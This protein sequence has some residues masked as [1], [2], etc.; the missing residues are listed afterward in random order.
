MK[1]FGQHG[2][3]Y[4]KHSDI[5]VMVW[6]CFAVSGLGHVGNSE[7]CSASIPIEML[8]HDLK[9]TV[10]ARRPTNVTELNQFCKKEWAK[11]PPRRCETLI[12][13]FRKRLI[14]VI[15]VQCGWRNGVG[16]FNS[17]LQ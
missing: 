4:V 15:A 1:L 8:W 7:F 5:S 6:G 17:W 3:C 9:C 10:Y 14:A 16:P 11:I 13:N 12:N 2:L